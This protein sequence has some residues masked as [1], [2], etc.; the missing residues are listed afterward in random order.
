MRQSCVCSV[1]AVVPSAGHP[2]VSLSPY[3]VRIALRMPLIRSQIFSIV[4][5]SFRLQLCMFESMS[6]SC[7]IC[8]VAESCAIS[9]MIPSIRTDRSSSASV[10]FRSSFPSVSAARSFHHLRLHMRVLRADPLCGVRLSLFRR[11]SRNFLLCQPMSSVSC[12][13]GFC[14]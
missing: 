1:S 4:S 7:W 6:T 9:S 8:S 13:I 3:D 2:A 12:G 5:M 10:P 14:W 11:P